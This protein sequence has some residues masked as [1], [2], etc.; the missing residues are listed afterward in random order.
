[1][2]QHPWNNLRY[3]TSTGTPTAPGKARASQQE[4]L[5]KVSEV[6]RLARCSQRTI[7]RAIHDGELQ[8]SKPA[9]R[10][11]VPR[12]AFDAWMRAGDSAPPTPTPVSAT[13]AKVTNGF[14]DVSRLLR[15]AARKA[16]AGG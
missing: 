1:M 14:D 4:P 13:R 5:L 9:G 3:A 16:R 10:W 15:D 11:L 6:A 8:A 12:V 7:L 2:Q